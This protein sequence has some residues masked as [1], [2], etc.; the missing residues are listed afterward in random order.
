LPRKEKLAVL[1]HVTYDKKSGR[2]PIAVYGSEL[3][4]IRRRIS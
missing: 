3:E 2:G 1:L 4:R